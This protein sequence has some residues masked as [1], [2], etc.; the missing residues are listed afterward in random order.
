MDKDREMRA[1]TASI[2]K[3]EQ[4]KTTRRQ[5]AEKNVNKVDREDDVA[6]VRRILEAFNGPFSIISRY[7]TYGVVLHDLALATEAALHCCLSQ[8]AS[9]LTDPKLW[10]ERRCQNRG[11][12]LE[13]SRFTIYFLHPPSA[14][15]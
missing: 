11:F 2:D 12:C 6:R 4:L 14:K 1:F 7:D 8:S 3:T 9:I 5:E 15:Q 10:S 13:A